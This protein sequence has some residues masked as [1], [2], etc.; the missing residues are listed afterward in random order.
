MTQRDPC[1]SSTSKACLKHE[2]NGFY[3]HDRVRVMF[4]RI[5][6]DHICVMLMNFIHPVVPWRKQIIISSYESPSQFPKGYTFIQMLLYN[7][8]GLHMLL[9]VL[10][11]SEKR[12]VPLFPQQLGAFAHVNV[13]VAQRSVQNVKCDFGSHFRFSFCGRSHVQAYFDFH[14]ILPRLRG[15][16]DGLI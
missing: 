13:F 10:E 2:I 14:S 8:K 15:C 11:R 6:Y 4:V 16:L 12:T 9:R 5:L 7:Y 3:S 1:S